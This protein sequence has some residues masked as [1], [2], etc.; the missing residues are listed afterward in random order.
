MYEHLLSTDFW[1]T[2]IFEERDHLETTEEY[3]VAGS[4]TESIGAIKVLQSSCLM[5]YWCTDE[6]GCQLHAFTSKL[7]SLTKLFVVV[8]FWS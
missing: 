2:V 1:S 7:V 4:N 5:T 8:L 6:P 3:V